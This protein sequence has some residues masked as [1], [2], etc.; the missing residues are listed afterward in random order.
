[1]DE[2]REPTTPET[3]SSGSTGGDETFGWTSDESGGAG[4]D[5][6]AA[7]ERMLAQLQSMIDTIATQAAPVVRQV[8]AKAA[9]LAAVA[10]DRAGPLAHRAADATAEASVKIAER[11]RTFAADLRSRTGDG[12][13]VD[14]TDAA[15]DSVPLQGVDDATEMAAKDDPAEGRP[16]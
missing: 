8:G 7:A 1:M 4:S 9:E 2:N 12:N 15:S 6:R 16:L 5:A 14:A 10:A 13:G 3:P 11:S